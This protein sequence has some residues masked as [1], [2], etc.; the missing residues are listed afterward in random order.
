M[1]LDPNNVFVDNIELNEIF[2]TIL[3]SS[4]EISEL[5]SESKTSA[6]S[7][8]TYSLSPVLFALCFVNSH[9]VESHQ[10]LIVQKV[11]DKVI[12]AFRLDNEIYATKM[13]QYLLL[14]RQMNALFEKF[15]SF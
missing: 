14:L 11:K 13:T 7:S 9:R 4:K 1:L 6:N 12:K 8:K 5:L 3:K 2:K 10:R 15:L